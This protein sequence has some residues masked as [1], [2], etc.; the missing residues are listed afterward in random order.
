MLAELWL[1]GDKPETRG[2]SLEIHP[3]LPRPQSDIAVMAATNS[4]GGCSL[5]DVLV[6]A[7][8]WESMSQEI[9]N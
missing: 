2:K 5:H 9:L 8:E 6:I 1:H 3:P 4:K 7:R